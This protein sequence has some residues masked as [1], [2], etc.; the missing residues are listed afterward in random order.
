MT[1]A[2]IPSDIIAVLNA[3]PWSESGALWGIRYSRSEMWNHTHIIPL[4]MAQHQGILAQDS[5]GNLIL[6][7]DGAGVDPVADKLP[8]IGQPVL[9]IHRSKGIV[10]TS[11]VS[12]VV[13]FGRFPILDLEPYGPAAGEPISGDSGSIF[14]MRDKS[15]RPVVVGM[16]IYAGWMPFARPGVSD[17]DPELTISQSENAMID[18]LRQPAPTVTATPPQTQQ[19]PQPP[20]P[21]DAL[22][23]A[24]ARIRQLTADNASLA[25]ANGDLRTQLNAEI[26]SHG[27]TKAKISRFLDAL[28]ELRN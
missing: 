17:Q 19:P 28:S 7:H 16:A 3:L 14:F 1:I 8:G 10:R 15:G 4:N 13:A 24:Q 6:K 5:A 22:S 26:V 18:L 2:D 20:F 12:R 11:R 23:E 25:M 21:V 27:E 9:Q